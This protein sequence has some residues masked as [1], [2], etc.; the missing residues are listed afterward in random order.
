[1]LTC[2]A[3]IGRSRVQD[4]G[5][6]DLVRQEGGAWLGGIQ[7]CGEIRPNGCTIVVDPSGVH[8]SGIQDDRCRGYRILHRTKEGSFECSGVLSWARPEAS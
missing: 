3:G 8:V 6:V 5:K 2:E 4:S 1:M 7:T